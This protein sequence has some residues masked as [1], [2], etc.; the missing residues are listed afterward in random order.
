MTRVKKKVISNVTLEQ[1][2]EASELYASKYLR[3][4]TIEAKINEEVAKIK[5]K[6]NEEVAKLQEELKEPEQVLMVF[7]EE[8]KSNWSKKS[9]ELLHTVIGFRT[10]TPKVDKTKKGFSW[11]AIVEL[12]KK[13]KSFKPFIRTKEEINK[14]AILQLRE[15]VEADAK[16]LNALKQEAFIEIK[17]DETVF[18][19]VKKEVLEKAA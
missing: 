4:S 5:A 1:A 3:L 18:V 15:E 12:L 14:E 19:E 16:I 13:N 8:Q 17:Q 9:F 7:A 2:Q 10:G 11:D 6:Y